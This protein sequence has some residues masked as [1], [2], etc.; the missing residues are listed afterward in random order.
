MGKIKM[1]VAHDL[2]RGI[3][4]DNK[5]V[6]HIPEDMKHFKETTMGHTVVMGRKTFES[7]GMKNGLAGRTNIVL[8][9]S[10]QQDLPF[11][12]N[13]YEAVLSRL[14]NSESDSFIIGGLEIYRLFFKHADEIIVTE[15]PN[16]YKCDT[17]FPELSVLEWQLIKTV[18][19]DQ[20]CFKYYQ[21]FDS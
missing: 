5:L 8:S 12:E 3:G 20:C 17:F 11:V 15:I 21:R 18:A 10:L 13:D 4:K 7:L 16:V 6:W 9:R 19:G 1:I 14:K 2:N